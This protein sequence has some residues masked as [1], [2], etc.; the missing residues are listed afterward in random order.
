MVVKRYDYHKRIAI[1]V[2]VLLVTVAGAQTTAISLQ[3]LQTA[4][5]YTTEIDMK[6]LYPSD[7]NYEDKVV[8][9]AAIFFDN[10]QIRLLIESFDKMVEKEEYRLLWDFI[11]ETYGDTIDLSRN[12]SGEWWITFNDLHSSYVFKESVFAKLIAQWIGPSFD[13]D[14]LEQ[15]VHPISNN[16]C[17][18]V[19]LH[20]AFKVGLD[21][22][23]DY[24]EAGEAVLQIVSFDLKKMQKYIEDPKNWEIFATAMNKDSEKLL[25]RFVFNDDVYIVQ[26]TRPEFRGD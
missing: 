25:G 12:Y 15:F 20:T 8:L 10:E 14:I 24:L 3:D 7:M 5:N 16:G 21:R 17:D 1:P 9:L 23:D 2:G 18:K 26:Y 4:L 22:H 11:R 6:N 13:A 19:R